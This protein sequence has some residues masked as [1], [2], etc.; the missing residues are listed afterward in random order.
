MNRVLGIGYFAVALL[1]GSSMAAGVF[2]RVELRWLDWQMGWLQQWQVAAA[3]GDVVVV[4]IDDASL[5]EFGVP[6]ATLHRQLGQFFE[7]MAIACVRAVGVDMVL[8]ES[9]FDRIQPG[10]DA[11]LARGIVALRPVAPLILGLGA[12]P[13]G[14]IRPLQP[15]FVTLVGQ[16]GLG[17]VFVARDADG[18]VRRFDERLGA[19]G[20]TFPTLAGQMARRLGVPVSAGIVPVHLGTR[21]K[22]VALNEVIS[23]HQAKDLARLEQ[24]FS[25]K[26]V[27]LGSILAHDDQH[28]VPVP[29]A[30]GD[31]GPMTHGVFIHAMQIRSLLAGNLI[32]EVPTALALGVAMFL[33]L[34]WWLRPGRVIW[35]SMGLAALVILGIS[36]LALAAGWAIPAVSWTM[37]L[38]AGLGART[39]WEAWLTAIEKRRLRRAFDGFVSPT[40]LK[41]ILG[42]RLHP[43]QTGERRDICVLFSDI[44]S[45]TTLSEHLAPEA[46]TDLLNRYF[47]RMAR[48]V[49]RHEGTLDKFIGDGIMA[50][51]G[52]PK[53]LDSPCESAFKAAQDM[54]AEL[55]EFNTEQQNHG[56]PRIAI[57]IGLHFGPAFVGYIGSAARNEYTAIGDTVNTASRLEG[58]TKEAGFP[59]VMSPTVV[60][61]LP[62]VVGIENLG[63][64]AVKGRAD[65]AVYGWR[66]HGETT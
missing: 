14:A 64:Q 19:E 49:H 26:V 18:V 62:G 38:L 8:P 31:T 7:A 50:F 23:W 27:L 35:I 65:I 63:Q 3:G 1:L 6:V 51:F 12:K 15:L 52:A 30:D 39:V 24:A 4:G 41:E 66:P 59:L 47:E 53:G 48:A 54:L 10:L 5:K 37:A 44:R 22:Y 42:G 9:S 13:D 32:K 25:G 46:V 57:G 40:V 60:Q 17:S 29:L 20:Q 34:G 2:G 43:S 33:T 16:E 36:P 45:F 11:S 55:E 28:S 21:F 58:L 61:R 56:G